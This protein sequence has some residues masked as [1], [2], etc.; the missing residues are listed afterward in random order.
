MKWN[1]RMSLSL[2]GLVIGGCTATTQLSSSIESSIS[3]ES[4]SS[5]STSLETSQL[6]S[7]SVS[8]LVVADSY[9]S[10]LLASYPDGTFYVSELSIDGYEDVIGAIIEVYQ[11]DELVSYVYELIANG[12]K[13][14]SCIYLIGIT[15]SGIF[16]TYVV[17][18]LPLQTVGVGTQVTESDFYNQFVDQS[19]TTTIN[20]I[21]GATYTSGGFIE[22]LSTVLDHFNSMT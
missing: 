17:I 14:A 3:S 13:D 4:V 10:E 1:K 22:A 8:S 12:Y 9:S 5:L 11:A 16:D 20:P 6:L 15:P 18:D 21:A 7:D 2:A 19:I